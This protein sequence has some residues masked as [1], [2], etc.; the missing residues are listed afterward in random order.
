MSKD[1][2]YSKGWDYL[3]KGKISLF[4]F[5]GSFSLLSFINFMFAIK[6]KDILFG[7]EKKSRVSK[8]GVFHILYFYLLTHVVSEHY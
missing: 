4:T 6:F 5:L 2:D 1:Q 7:K 8:P 3:V